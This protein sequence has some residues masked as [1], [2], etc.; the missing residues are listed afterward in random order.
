MSSYEQALALLEEDPALSPGQRRARAAQQAAQDQLNLT[1]RAQEQVAQ[2]RGQ[3]EENYIRQNT[4]DGVP[5]DVYSGL[6]GGQRAKLSFE[7]NLDK[8]ADW[9]AKQPGVIGVRKTTDGSNLI[10]RVEGE[11]GLR[12]V[13]V[14]ERG[15]TKRDIAEMAGDTP[16]MAAATGAALLTGGQSL[17]LQ[18]LAAGGASFATGAGQDAIVRGVTDA[19]IDPGEIAAARG[20]Q[21]SI[22]AGLPLAGG[23]GKRALQS[24]VAPF[25]RTAGVLEREALEAAGRL[26]VPLTAAQRT[27]NPALA[28]A[29]AFVSNL[30]GGGPLKDQARRQAEAIR[31]VQEFLVGPD[32]LPSESSIAR[33]AQEKLGSMRAADAGRLAARREAAAKTAQRDIQ[34]LLDSSIAPPNLSQSEAGALLRSR[35]AGLRDS[36]RTKARANYDAV[37][38]AAGGAEV[39]VPMGPVKSMLGGVAKNTS[40]ASKTLVPG[41][42]TILG[43]GE[44]LPANMPLNQALELRTIINDHI[45]RGVPIGDVSDRYLKKTAA[46]LTQAI[47][48]G[49]DSAPNKT[50]GLALA[51][52]NRYYRENLPKFTQRGIS[53]LFREAS[54][55]GFVDDSRIISR[56]FDGR[57]D[58]DMLRRSAQLLGPKSKEYRAIVRTGLQRM[59]D[60]SIPL[61][62]GYIDAASFLKRL[63]HL[64]PEI[65]RAIFSPETEKALVGSTRLLGAARG[66]RLDPLDVE[67]LAEARPGQAANILRQA[68]RREQIYD[69]RYN[70]QIMAQ[71]MDGA[72]DPAK[73][74]PDEFVS[75]FVN[76][77]SKEDVRRVLTALRWKG[78]R[79]VVEGIRRR[80]LVDLLNKS[81]RGFTPEDTVGAQ[82]GDIAFDKLSRELRADGDKLKVVLGQE[83]MDT[84]S[85]LAKVSA[86]KA[87]A[88]ATGGAAGQL[89]YSNELA[90]MMNL[91][92]ATTLPRMV[93]NRVVATML[94]VPGLNKWLAQTSVQ[95]PATPRLRAAM[96]S[97][98]PMIRA[99]IE[100][101]REEPDKLGQVLDVVREDPGFVEA[102]EQANGYQRAMSLF[103]EVED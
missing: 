34:A 48:K 33:A 38:E 88:E 8:R 90:K 72:L 37:Y 95:V 45:A 102:R 71:L 100:E 26:N 12:D 59:V 29:E 19:E 81:G 96:F 73:L 84:L 58:V 49:V 44:D 18:A 25:G 80:T 76:N 5:L 11:N 74:N 14:D 69:Q 23:A 82:S 61:G 20:L 78:G 7:R 54:D 50:L 75:R 46:A 36:F 103:E 17:W 65:R 57:G 40:E 43:F 13:L 21:A 86:V 10:A 15:F 31:Q 4:A 41:I 24:I 53:D 70:K 99:L 93:K 55:G 89:V 87:K 51:E 32:P 27:G 85:A 42:R 79:D 91:Q 39:T 60:D 92:L 2:R 3:A 22:D 9:L 62:E 94:T 98:P 35:A 30:P 83:T 97:S 66:V 28:R 1:A 52:A 56:L 68:A 64:D 63:K 67:K 77:A 16:Q 101:F 6:P 47:E